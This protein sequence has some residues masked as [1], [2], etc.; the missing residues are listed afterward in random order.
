MHGSTN[1]TRR[2]A[3]KMVSNEIKVILTMCPGKHNLA[4]THASPRVVF[5]NYGNKVC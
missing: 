3:N 5:K 2:N 4:G 1:R